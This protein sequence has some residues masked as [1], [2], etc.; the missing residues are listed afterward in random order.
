MPTSS[1][2]QLIRHAIISSHNLC[3]GQAHAFQSSADKLP[4]AL[5][6]QTMASAAT[7]NSSLQPQPSCS[8]LEHDELQELDIH[9]RGV[10]ELLSDVEK[11]MP[12]ELK[13]FESDLQALFAKLHSGLA[14]QDIYSLLSKIE[15]LV[16]ESVWVGMMR[17]QP[18][19]G[20]ASKVRNVMERLDELG[21][22]LN[23]RYRD[24]EIK[25]DTKH[26]EP[27]VLLQFRRAEQDSL[28][29]AC[30]TSYRRVG[31]LWKP[32]AISRN[33]AQTAVYR[34]PH[35]EIGTRSRPTEAQPAELE[36]SM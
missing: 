34:S 13:L 17:I 2:C 3:E 18:K 12:L 29:S 23:F 5:R 10:Q 11:P 31:I 16:E 21:C 19:P 8:M 32:S 6:L 28:S 15:A 25:V 36:R 33:A 30:I 1:L 14:T 27:H 22:Y 26:G 20:V 35:E 7:E 9:I 24:P 4:R